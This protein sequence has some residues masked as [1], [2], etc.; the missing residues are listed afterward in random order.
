M[1]KVEVVEEGGEELIRAVAR[2]TSSF[3]LTTND[4]MI[5]ALP[6]GHPCAI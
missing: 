1:E 4:P 6:L 2:T 3:N 5:P